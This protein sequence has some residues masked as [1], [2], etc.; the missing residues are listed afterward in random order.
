M[1][2]FFNVFQLLK[3]TQPPQALSDPFGLEAE[4]KNKRRARENSAPAEA[5]LGGT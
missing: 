3:M 4:P 5:A 2:T 1:S